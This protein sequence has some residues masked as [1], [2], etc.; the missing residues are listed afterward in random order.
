MKKSVDKKE[1]KKL[2]DAGEEMPHVHIE[3]GSVK[4]YV[5]LEDE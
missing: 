1:V 5:K 4:F 2:L 3:P